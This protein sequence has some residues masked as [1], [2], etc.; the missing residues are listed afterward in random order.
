[1]FIWRKNINYMYAW[2]LT[3]NLSHNKKIIIIF[4]DKI[5][6]K[7]LAIY[8]SQKLDIFLTLKSNSIITQFKMNGMFDNLKFISKYYIDANPM[9]GKFWI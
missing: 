9:F 8:M 1:M 7:M 4:Y 5:K 2:K 3:I 6:W